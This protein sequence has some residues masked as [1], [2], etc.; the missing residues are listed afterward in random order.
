MMKTLVAASGLGCCQVG[1]DIRTQVLEASSDQ[2]EHC[3][4]NDETP[5]SM[6][7]SG[8]AQRRRAAAGIRL[9]ERSVQLSDRRPSKVTRSDLIASSRAPSSASDGNSIAVPDM[10]YRRSGKTPKRA[11]T[12][13][14]GIPFFCMG[15]QR[16]A[17]GPSPPPQN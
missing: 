17:P 13:N 7:K 5:L 8:G 15:S 12:E 3:R 6:D 1:A 16:I 10:C 14:D 2:K 9:A 4:K 11:N